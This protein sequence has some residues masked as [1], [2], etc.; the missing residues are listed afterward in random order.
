LFCQRIHDV[1][2]TVRSLRGS[3]RRLHDV[4]GC[5]YGQWASWWYAWSVNIL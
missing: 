4:T 2:I 5:R 3:G 1:V